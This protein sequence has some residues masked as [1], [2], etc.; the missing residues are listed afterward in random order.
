MEA[1]TFRTPVEFSN[2]WDTRDAWKAR[3]YIFFVPRSRQYMDEHADTDKCIYRWTPFF[4]IY[5]H[6]DDALEYFVGP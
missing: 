6:T 3:S 5:H 2:Q 4:F 1:M